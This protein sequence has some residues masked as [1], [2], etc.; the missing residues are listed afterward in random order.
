MT[1]YERLLKK[2]WKEKLSKEEQNLFL[3]A[4]R[5][6]LSDDMEYQRE[7]IK[8]LSTYLNEKILQMKKEYTNK[9]KVV[10]I[11]CLCMGSNFAFLKET[12]SVKK[13]RKMTIEL[14]FKIAAVGILVT[15]LGQVLKHSG[16]EEQAFLVSLAGLF[17]V[18]S[19]IIPCISELFTEIYSLFQL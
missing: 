9:K 3:N 17:I 5:N 19:W 14:I 16:R 7:E 8:Q 18:L 4:G 13:E 1:I 10:L 6:L 15:I 12:G 2:T 11:S